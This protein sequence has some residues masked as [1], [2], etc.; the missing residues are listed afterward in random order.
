MHN[1]SDYLYCDF[2]AFI[3]VDVRQHVSDEVQEYPFEE[4]CFKDPVEVYQRRN[5]QGMKFPE[6]LLHSFRA[7][8]KLVDSH[9]FE[10]KEFQKSIVLF[11][12][13]ILDVYYFLA[14]CDG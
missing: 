4:M 6:D 12:L 11:F 10:A 2:G 1:R 8:T 14:V 9:T 5:S 3:G 13:L 7:H